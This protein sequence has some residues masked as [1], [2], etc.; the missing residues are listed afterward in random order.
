MICQ[1]VPLSE[2][3][4]S[5]PTLI[6][7]ERLKVP[8]QLIPSDRAIG[9]TSEGFICGVRETPLG[10]VWTLLSKTPEFKR[11]GHTSIIRAI[12]LVQ[13][14]TKESLDFTR[15]LSYQYNK[16]IPELIG[17]PLDRS[18]FVRRKKA[19]VRLYS[20]I[21]CGYKGSSPGACP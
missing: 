19:K 13:V 14:D 16:G 5:E 15:L 12:S 21:C 4:K 9:L 7:P 1:G 17:I 2:K 8:F 6:V 3:N 20:L 11:L 18:I 10:T